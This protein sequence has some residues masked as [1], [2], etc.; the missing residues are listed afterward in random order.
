MSLTITSGHAAIGKVEPT[1]AFRSNLVHVQYN[2]HNIIRRI[3]H[4]KVDQIG[5]TVQR[6]AVQTGNGTP[7]MI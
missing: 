2:E 1:V 3:Q 4:L 7:V 6:S 5:K